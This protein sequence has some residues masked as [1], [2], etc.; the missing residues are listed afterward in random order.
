[1]VPL[2]RRS[3]A[4]DR[5]VDNAIDLQK[6]TWDIC[7]TLP[8]SYT[9]KITNELLDSA[10]KIVRWSQYAD[11]VVLRDTKDYEEK[12]KW[13]ELAY[14]ECAFLYA[15]M[16][17]LYERNPI[18]ESLILEWNQ[19]ADNEMEYLNNIDKVTLG[20]LEKIRKKMSKGEKEKS[21]W[22]VFFER[23]MNEFLPVVVNAIK[24]DP[25]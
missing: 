19:Y 1:M 4:R 25:F 9:F 8:K 15:E 14:K 2:S 12:M 18:K 22:D 24:E 6:V 21:V 11:T 13:I 7:D 17:V 23:L 16:G 3:T 10:K 20:K 5:Y